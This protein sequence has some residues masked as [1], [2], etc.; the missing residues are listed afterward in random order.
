M[1]GNTLYVYVYAYHDI[2]DRKRLYSKKYTARD[3]GIRWFHD[4]YPTTEG[5]FWGIKRA[6][7]RPLFETRKLDERAR[8]SYLAGLLVD[9]FDDDESFWTAV[10][11]SEA[12]L[13]CDMPYDMEGLRTALREE[14]GPD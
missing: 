3:Y 11:D 10:D 6:G 12:L 13:I 4:S 8:I 2:S 9:L 1:K 5:S 7:L 14:C